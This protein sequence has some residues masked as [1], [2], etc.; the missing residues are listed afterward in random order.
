VNGVVYGDWF[1]PSKG[2]LNQMYANWNVIGGFSSGAFWS[3][4]EYDA[5]YAWF[6]GFANGDQNNYNK[7]NPGYVRPVRAF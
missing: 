2:E 6:H 5:S 3:S 4:S 7:A 1:L